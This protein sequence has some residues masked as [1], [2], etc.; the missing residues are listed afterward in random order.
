M[1]RVYHNW[2]AVLNRNVFKFDFKISTDFDCLMNNGAGPRT[3]KALSPYFL[4]VF[5]VFKRCCD[6]EWS[7]LDGWYGI[8]M[9]ARQLGPWWFMDLY[10]NSRIQ[11]ENGTVCSYECVDNKDVYNT[12]LNV[13]MGLFSGAGKIERRKEE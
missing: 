8:S 5:F 1:S 9:S 13:R 7:D 11:S 12:A 4:F 3:A 10:T 6:K 2:N